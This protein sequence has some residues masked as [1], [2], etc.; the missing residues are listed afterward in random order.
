MSARDAGPGRDLTPLFDPRSIA[1]VGASSDASKWGGDVAARL[2]RGGDRRRLFFVNHRGGLVQGRESS[3]SLRELPESPDM[4]IL[5]VPAQAFEAALDDGL[6]VGA[7]AFV[8][9]LAGLGETGAGGKARE[10]AAVAR[11]RTAGAVMIGPNCMGV[12]DTASGL[13]A[14]AYLDVPAGGLA[15]VS[16]SGGLGEELVVRALEQGVGFSRYVT[17]GNQADLGVTDVLTALVDHA[18]TRVVAVYGEDLGD[19]RA[20][21]RAARDLVASGRPVVLLSPGRS[22]ASARVARSH[23]GSL[24]PDAAVLDAACHAAGVVRVAT[25]GELFDAAVCLLP[26]RRARGRRLAVVSDGG[27]HGGLAADVAAAAGLDVSPLSPAVVTRVR[28]ALAASVG[29]NPFDFAIG[30]IEPAA[31]GAV[32][33]AVVEADGVDTVLA[34][35]QLG[36]WGARF[37]HFT[38]QVAAER[39]GARRI[40]AAAARSGTPV[41]VCSTYPRSPAAAALRESGI[42]VYHETDAAVTALRHLV[43]VHEAEGRLEEERDGRRAD[44]LPEV[45]PSAPPLAGLVAAVAAEAR[46]A[47]DVADNGTKAAAPPVSAGNGAAAAIARDYWLAREA[48]IAA[49]LELVDARRALDGEEA[50]AAAAD[51]GYPVAL[52]AL[53]LLHKSDQGGVAL[54]IGGAG[55]LRAT[56]GDMHARLAPPEYAVERMA[57]VADGVELIV[58]CRWDPHFGPVVLV[59]L[60]GLYAELL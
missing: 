39:D 59:G 4:V 40:G 12:A 58:G 15:F 30:T 32:V 48:L 52:K 36:Y 42:P 29:E 6:A 2:A 1:V 46:A 7:R 18:P 37:A 26:G 3:R 53:G 44:G 11:L 50:V 13:Q 55:E 22:A 16:Q 25:V 60:G 14:V 35:G 38:D 17:V 5:A 57:P 8:G 24:A 49:G 20:F 51:L 10:R 19:G 54:G 45:P 28:A 56:V 27:G 47:G 43:A 31:Y 41:V 34:V 9:I 21:A 33:D 23:T